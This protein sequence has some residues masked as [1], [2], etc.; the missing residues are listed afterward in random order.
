MTLRSDATTGRMHLRPRKAGRRE[1]NAAGRQ[2]ATQAAGGG[3]VGNRIHSTPTDAVIRRRPP[4][5]RT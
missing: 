2:R 5:F 4:A 3:I 1:V